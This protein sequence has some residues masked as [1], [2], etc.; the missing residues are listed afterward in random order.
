IC[1]DLSEI[2]LAFDP[3]DRVYSLWGFSEKKGREEGREEIG[4][5]DLGCG[6]E[7]KRG[8]RWALVR[9]KD[10]GGVVLRFHPSGGSSR[11][12]E[13]KGGRVIGDSGLLAVVDGIDGVNG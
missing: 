13:D 2:D 1:E 3:E 4:V 9:R 11:L 7:R 12:C 8:R 5:E 6:E 10:G